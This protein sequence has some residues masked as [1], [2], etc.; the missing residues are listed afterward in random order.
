MSSR[1][2]GSASKVL[3]GAG[4]RATARLSPLPTAWQLPSAWQPVRGLAS[5]RRIPGMSGIRV[6]KSGDGAARCSFAPEAGRRFLSGEQPPKGGERGPK[7]TEEEEED[8]D[9]PAQVDTNLP[10]SLRAE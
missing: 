3:G 4:V 10:K 6:E 8:S 7:Q 5:L 2:W 9:G 1:I